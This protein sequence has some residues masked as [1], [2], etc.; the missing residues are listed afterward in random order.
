MRVALVAGPAPGHAFPAAALAI[1]LRDA[2]AEVRLVTGAQWL[3]AV[4]R[5]GIGGERLPLLA[6]D[7]RDGDV[8]FVLYERA[9]Q[10]APPLARLLGRFAP[11]LVV[12]DTLT[13]AGGFAAG[14]L[15]VPWVELVP[16]P[17]PD[18]SRA[19]PAPGTGR[20]AGGGPL[21]GVRDA[22]V[23]RLAARDRARG[24][25]ALV[26]ARR[27][28]GLRALVTSPRSSRPATS[29]TMMVRLT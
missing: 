25:A 8:G 9:A 11:D 13:L 16:H 3:P 18:I 29:F 4:A 28:L 27:S 5:D 15:A 1:A 17:L 7:P 26:A 22:L 23:R 21:A 20:P 14:L 10:M 19:L 24:R 12:A 6:P 2:G